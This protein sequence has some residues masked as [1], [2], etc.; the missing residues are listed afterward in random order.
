MGTAVKS[1]DGKEQLVY[2][3]DTQGVQ[4]IT[5]D[6]ALVTDVVTITIKDVYPGSKYEDTCISE[7]D[8][9]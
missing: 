5:F 3:D 4:D 8:F 1:G 9:Y 7:I 6:E 2:L